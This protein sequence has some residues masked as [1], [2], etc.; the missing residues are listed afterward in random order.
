MKPYI[1]I[2]SDCF[3]EA[4]VSRV[5]WIVLGLITFLLLALT[6]LSV[7]EQFAMKVRTNEVFA[8]E[9][10]LAQI[11][12]EGKGN[13]QTPAAAIWGLLDEGSKESIDEALVEGEE[14][15]RA[16]RESLSEVLDAL[17]DIEDPN[18]LS[19]SDAFSGVALSE[20]AQD[21]MDRRGDGLSDD[22]GR[23]LNRFLIGGAFPRA[24]FLRNLAETHVSYFIWGKD[25]DAI[26]IPKDELLKNAL[27]AVTTFLLGTLGVMLA[28]LITATMIPQTFDKG[29]ID[30]LLSKPL[31]RPLL[32]LAKYVGGCAFIAICT[33][34]L[35][36]GLCFLAALRWDYWEPRMLLGIPI[37]L[38]LFGIYYS[39]S[40]FAGVLWRNP[41]VSVFL[42]VA[43]WALC[44]GVGTSRTV[45]REVF[46]ASSQ[47]TA[48]LPLESGPIARTESNVITRWTNE[49][50]TEPWSVLEDVSES[51]VFPAQMSRV[52]GPVY[53][54]DQDRIVFLRS[55]GSGMG[56]R[57]SSGGNSAATIVGGPGTDWTLDD[58]PELTDLPSGMYA[59]DGG[60]ITVTGRRGMQR[61]VMDSD[62]NESFK[63]IG[64]DVAMAPPISVSLDAATRGLAIWDGSN[65][66]VYRVDESGMYRPSLKKELG[67]LG[68][69]LVSFRAGTIAIVTDDGDLRSFNAADLEE[70]HAFSLPVDSPPRYIE[71]SLDGAW[72]AVVYHD[73][74][75]RVAD[76]RAGS[77]SEPRIAERRNVFAVAFSDD[78]DLW[79]TG[80]YRRMSVYDPETMRSQEKYWPKMNTVEKIER[81]VLEPVYTVFPKPGELSSVI[82]YLMTGEESVS[83]D[84]S[85]M[86][87]R[88]V[89]SNIWGT[90]WSNL[91]F[92]C[93]TLG[94]ACIHIQ[95]KDF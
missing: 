83:G 63:N 39:V 86:S 7:T 24:I 94:L 88:R 61:L 60:G 58:G 47:A 41:V 75:L 85:N 54:K 53:D 49:D 48:I 3:H 76:Q 65:L 17:N 28:I 72:T 55:R 50:E 91:A 44:A 18:T 56:R 11:A 71:S 59:D 27:T 80:K 43:F 89:Q 64:P 67:Q 25:I 16:I 95:R 79:V 1:A 9:Q 92:L 40:A 21:L 82:A 22:E 20:E 66:A 4:F 68:Q 10:F 45:I 78:G 73:G 23:R 26:P 70:M 14:N 35:V 36:G 87:A 46:L 6:P 57:R 12:S 93:V 37:F 42:T 69:G 8:P 2:I 29:A 31:N 81:Y 77:W 19:G 32:F 34:F 74:S 15:R 90:I 52:T 84:S 13:S 33:T 62:G 5:L 38:F 30:L 51:S